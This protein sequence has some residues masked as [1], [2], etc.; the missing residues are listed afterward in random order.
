MKNDKYEDF[1]LYHYLDY[2]YTYIGY[3]KQGISCGKGLVIRG[4]TIVCGQ[5]TDNC[6]C[7]GVLV[8]HNM[9]Y[10]GDIE[11]DNWRFEHCKV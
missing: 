1:G 9:R 6:N 10:E 2:N 7:N 4:S 3:Y 11:G 5:F 8:A